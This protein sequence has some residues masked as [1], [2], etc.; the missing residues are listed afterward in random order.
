MTVSLNEMK[1][2][3]NSNSFLR[4]VFM[5]SLCLCGFPEG[6]SSN[7]QVSLSSDPIFPICVSV[8]G[9]LSLLVGPVIDW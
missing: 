5:F 1:L 9:Y 6:T 2:D 8:N 7:R 3:L 4:G